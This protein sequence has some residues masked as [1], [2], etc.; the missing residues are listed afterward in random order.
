MSFVIQARRESFGWYI[1]KLHLLCG[2]KIVAQKFLNGNLKSYSKMSSK[3][4]TLL[5]M[6]TNFWYFFF[7]PNFVE[8]PGIFVECRGLRLERV[9]FVAEICEVVL[10]LYRLQMQFQVYISV[11]HVERGNSISSHIQAM[12]TACWPLM[13]YGYTKNM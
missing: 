10:N 5:K 4:S 12:P 6:K 7:C 9:L 11:H 13:N 1:R 3:W 2:S 8:T